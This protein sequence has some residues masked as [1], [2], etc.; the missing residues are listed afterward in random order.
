MNY[1]GLFNGL[2]RVPYTHQREA[3][4]FAQGKQHVSLLWEMGT[5]KTGGAILLARSKYADHGRLLRT[6][7]ITPPVTITNWKNEFNL[8][9]KIPSTHVHAMVQSSGAKKTE[10]S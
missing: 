5:G 2:G 10:I 9:S 7:I 1:E 4:Y 3:V 8:W 6:L